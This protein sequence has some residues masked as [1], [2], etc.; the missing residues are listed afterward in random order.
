ML[1]PFMRD[2]ILP[3]FVDL[4]VFQ[5]RKSGPLFQTSPVSNQ[6]VG[7]AVEARLH[8]SP[9]QS[10]VA[11]HTCPLACAALLEDFLVP[12]LRP[13]TCPASL[14]CVRQNLRCQC[15][16][17]A[18]AMHCKP[19]RTVRLISIMV[20]N[21]RPST[22]AE[23]CP[24]KPAQLP[25]CVVFRDRSPSAITGGSTSSSERVKSP[26]PRTTRLVCWSVFK[27]GQKLACLSGAG[28][29]PRR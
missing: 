12:S 8:P 5:P 15:V 3:F 29:P 14:V 20:L 13:R 27:I 22:D 6:N 2:A 25:H 17:L 21:R 24:P 10:R 4:R 16:M 28:D 1:L 23:A 19:R 9:V 18:F 26:S 7:L 11:T